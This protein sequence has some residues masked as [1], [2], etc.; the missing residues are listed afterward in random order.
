MRGELV[1]LFVDRKVSLWRV[2][3][4]YVDAKYTVVVEKN[5]VRVYRNINWGGMRL[6]K[7]ITEDQ[8]K[9]C[10]TCPCSRRT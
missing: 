1:I 10:Q 7:T 2:C 6:I 9:A 4:E 3:G 5:R 8:Y